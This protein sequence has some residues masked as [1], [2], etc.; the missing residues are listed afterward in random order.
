[1]QMGDD[2]T[3]VEYYR[4]SSIDVCVC[5]HT[6]RSDVV[7]NVAEGTIS[8][9]VHFPSGRRRPTQSRSARCP[10]SALACR[11]REEE[12]ARGV[13]ISCWFVVDTNPGIFLDVHI[14]RSHSLRESKK[15]GNE[16]VVEDPVRNLIIEDIIDFYFVH[17]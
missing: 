16:R 11:R 7:T 2:S 13:F 6:I 9:H 15:R 1:M 5:D 3:F 4:L 10:G 14:V 12:F 8:N 17:D